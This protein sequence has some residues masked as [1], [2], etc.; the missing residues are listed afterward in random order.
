MELKSILGRCRRLLIS[1]SLNVSADTVFSIR[2]ALAT[3]FAESRPLLVR[4]ADSIRLV[5]VL[6]SVYEKAVR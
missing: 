6:L 4:L 3:E 1:V 2:S 5:L